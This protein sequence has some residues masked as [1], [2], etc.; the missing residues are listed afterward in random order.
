MVHSPLHAPARPSLSCETPELGENRRDFLKKAGLCSMAGGLLAAMDVFSSA[1][2][3]EEAVSQTVSEH[4]RRTTHD[5]SVFELPRWTP[6]KTG[7]F[8]LADPL[9]NHFAWAKVQAN[10]AGEYSWLAQY[11][12]ILIAP[13]NE[14]AYPFLGRIA[15]AKIFVTPTNESFAANIGEH[16]YMIWGTFTTIHVDPRTFEPVDRILN[17]YTGKVIDVPTLHYADNLVF[18]LGQSIVVPGVD[19]AFYTQPWDADGGFSQ[20][21]IDAGDEISYTV[22]GAAQKSGPHQ[23]RCD[24]GFWSAKRSELMNPRLRAI[25]IRRDYSV[26]QK[27]SEYQWYGAEAGDEAQLFAHLTGAKVHDQRKLPGFV[28]TLILDRFASRFA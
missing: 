15:L 28:K 21:F 17:P 18:R 24:V 22:L 14:P 11:G 6:D 16:D 4:R 19:P 20:H 12:W 2:A 23:P 7:A 25:D 1:S 9:D 13:P 10:L 5:P 3:E 8:N 26:I 27:M